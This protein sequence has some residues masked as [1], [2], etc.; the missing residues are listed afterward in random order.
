[1][2]ILVLCFE[3]SRTSC[4]NIYICHSHDEDV[5]AT[6]AA[7]ASGYSLPRDFLNPDTRDIIRQCARARAHA[8]ARARARA[9]DI[10]RKERPRRI[11]PL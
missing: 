5:A 10:R 3:Y 7:S 4:I 1:M 9:R 2:C 11:N 6:A 8:R